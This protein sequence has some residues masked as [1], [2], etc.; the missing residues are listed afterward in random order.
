VEWLL[1]SAATDVGGGEFRATITTTDP[2]YFFR[3]FPQL[4]R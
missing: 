2:R 1:P 4:K 3:A